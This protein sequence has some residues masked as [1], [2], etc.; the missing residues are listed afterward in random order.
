MPVQVQFDGSLRIL[1]VVYE[2]NIRGWDISEVYKE[3]AHH[4][5]ELR[6]SAVIVDFAAIT[7]F[8]VPGDI[9]RFQAKKDVALLG[10]T[11][12]PVVLVIPR[13]QHLFGLA[14]MYELSANP[15]F[16]E[17][18]IVHSREEALTGL[19]IVSPNFDK[20]VLPERRSDA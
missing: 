3:I 12:T 2:G 6:P 7:S 4:F 14:R 9:V 5:D 17:L 8:D 20:L 15:P 10:D 11:N 18:R 1:L 16:P 19:N 13:Q